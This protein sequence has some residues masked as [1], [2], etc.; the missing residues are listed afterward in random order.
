MSVSMFGVKGRFLLCLGC[1]MASVASLVAQSFWPGV[2]PLEVQLKDENPQ[3]SGDTGTTAEG[4]WLH[5]GVRSI[6]RGSGVNLELAPGAILTRSFVIQALVDPEPEKQDSPD[7]VLE[8]YLWVSADIL[9][10]VDSGGKVGVV[11]LSL[12][13]P[14]SKDKP[15]LVQQAVTGSAVPEDYV[16]VKGTAQRP[17]NGRTAARALDGD[18]RTEWVSVFPKGYDK[19]PSIQLNFDQPRKVDGLRYL[20]RQGGLKNGQVYRY[21]I[22]IR[23][24]N[25]ASYETVATG[26][27]DQGPEEKSVRF[28]SAHTVQSI[29]LIGV[30]TKADPN[31]HVCMS[32]SEVTPS[33]VMPGSGISQTS[34]SEQRVSAILPSQ[35]LSKLHGK[36]LELTFQNHSKHPLL[37]GPIYCSQLPVTPPKRK[38]RPRHSE[39]TDLNAIGMVARTCPR[40]QWPVAQVF[41]IEE[42][43]P[44]SRSDI[45]VGDL[46]IGVGSQPLEKPVLNVTAYPLDEE[47]MM[48]HHEP[49]ISRHYY[50]A[51]KTGT[52]LYF[53]VIDPITGKESRKP[54]RPPMYGSEDFTGF[55]LSG[56]AADTLYEEL[57]QRVLKDQKED[58]S[59]KTMPANSSETYG[60]MALLGTRDPSHAPAIHRAANYIL[61]QPWTGHES[62]YLELWNMAFKTLA[63]GEYALA[64][65][66]PR[67]IAWLDNICRGMTQG[68]HVNSR[69]YFTFGHDRRGLPYGN[70]GLIAPLSHIIVGDALAYRAGVKTPAW[71]YFLPYNKAAWADNMPMGKQCIGYGAPSSGGG[72]DQAWCRSG[73]IGLA[74]SLRDTEPALQQGVAAYMKSHHG[75]MRRSHGYGAMGSYLGLMALAGVDESAFQHVMEQWAPVIAMQWQRGKGLRHVEPQITNVGCVSGKSS[76][77]C[78]SYTMAA[79]LS[80]RQHG[81]HC[82]GAKDT[83]WLPYPEDV[84][85][86]QPVLIHE[87]EGVNVAR[88]SLLHY[89]TARYTKDGS[90]P[91]K[92]SPVWKPGTG[93]DG[94]HLTVA[95]QSSHGVMGDPTSIHLGRECP[96]QWSV[97]EASCGFPDET[98]GLDVSKI[99]LARARN[100]F[101]GNPSTAFRV[102]NSSSSGGLSIWS[103]TVDR[104]VSEGDRPLIIRVTVPSSKHERKNINDSARTLVVESSED[105]KVWKKD[106]AGTIPED[107]VVPLKRGTKA[108]YLKFTFESFSGTNLIV[109]DLKFSYQQ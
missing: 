49:T 72:S 73:L 17:H 65:G 69:S 40:E 99:S 104:G 3:S 102:N 30:D 86:P 2:V 20:P 84:K 28:E 89:V 108:R 56:P 70:G 74:C 81:L 105:G 52:P 96:S 16:R 45:K 90:S 26:E 23:R 8:S 82:T 57:I 21:E 55:P 41:R 35:K 14:E 37:L 11:S 94:D 47:W 15:G 6:Q 18:P 66:D 51:I 9:G 62:S 97:V 103:V 106:S 63:L 59:W 79:L 46:I 31:Q 77:D 83:Q 53:D 39:F 78:Y 34:E 100:A 12:S 61:E 42:G 87:S 60:M 32:A 98:I 7:R 4:V 13:S 1:G 19:K 64:T 92:D 36:V 95:Y 71:E 91:G 75:F 25:N 80:V 22:Q 58:G 50:Q 5:T 109:P 101:D 88:P 107:R 10:M 33:Y 76:D 38:Y 48:R 44:V 24:E 43:L 68:G 27:W 29:R 67:A 93:N 85:P 54:V